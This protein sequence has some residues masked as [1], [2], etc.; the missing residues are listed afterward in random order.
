MNIARLL[1]ISALSVFL[2]AAGA[3]AQT[4]PSRQLQQLHDALNLR[5]DQDTNWQDYVRSTAV[6]PQEMAERREASQRMAGLTA[7]GRVDLSVQMMKADL[8][9][10]ERRGAALKI[11]YDSL[12][13]EQK[14]VFD[15]E[16]MRPPQGM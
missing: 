3:H 15:R 16:T 1:S 5:P 4:P 14:A 12:T 10:L 8:A 2:L 11:F 13:P 7:P 6:D 9:S